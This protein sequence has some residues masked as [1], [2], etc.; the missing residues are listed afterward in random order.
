MRR[1]CIILR[2]SFLQ[3]LSKSWLDAVRSRNAHPVMIFLDLPVSSRVVAVFLC[4]QVVSWL[5]FP[6]ESWL[7]FLLNIIRDGI[8]LSMLLFPAR[9]WPFTTVFEKV[10]RPTWDASPA[11]SSRVVAGCGLFMR[12]TFSRGYSL[13]CCVP[14]DPSLFVAHSVIRAS[15]S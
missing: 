13:F 15:T 3:C 11:T 4:I 14:A 9:S 10:S 12:C 8:A 5:V 7:V 1:H 2:C 6:A